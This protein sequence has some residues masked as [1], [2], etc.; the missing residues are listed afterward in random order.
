VPPHSEQIAKFLRLS[1]HEL[2]SIMADTGPIEGAGTADESNREL[3]GKAWFAL[4]ANEFREKVCLFPAV[5][6]S[7]GSNTEH[8]PVVLVGLVL[9]AIAA[10]EG[11]PTLLAFAA[12][13][14][15][16]GLHRYCLPNSA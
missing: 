12:L 2:F 14:V 7:L 5:V 1:D 11:Q 8:D 10:V 9:D 13:L 15:R 3:I 4:K 6:Y 16:R